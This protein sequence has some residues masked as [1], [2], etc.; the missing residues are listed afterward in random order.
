MMLVSVVIPCYNQAH[1]LGEAIESVASQTYEAIET[2]VVDDGST[3]DTAEVASSHAVRCVRQ[4]NQGVAEARNAGMRAARGDVLLFLDSDDLLAPTAVEGGISCL[5]VHPDAAFVFGR[6]DVVGLARPWVPPLVQ[7]DYYRH[8]LESNIIWMPGL[9]L[10]RKG[11]LEGLGGFDSHF[12]GAADW[13]LY[14][15]I[16][17][18]FPIGFC[19]GVHGTYRRHRESMS[20]D[21]AA[22]FLDTTIALR[23]QRQ[24]VWK[25]RRYRQSYRRGHQNLRKAYGRWVVVEARQAIADGRLRKARSSLGILLR[26]EPRGFVSALAWGLL[27][28]AAHFARRTTGAT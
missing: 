15:R 23:T 28:L 25:N 19:A 1:F 21:S 18:R 14:L 20:N 9:V 2:I 5:R 17:S 11:I 16:A 24:H 13:E 6:P 26:Y 4:Q 27:R 22:M 12:N 10:Y 7:S 3:D 8:L